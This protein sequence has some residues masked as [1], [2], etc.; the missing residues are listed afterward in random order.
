MNNAHLFIEAQDVFNR[1]ENVIAHFRAKGLTGSALQDIILFSYDLQSGS[2][3]KL[4]QENQKFQELAGSKGA[5]IAG[6]L[7]SLNIK[8]V[9]EAGTGEATTLRCV[10]ESCATDI[11]FSAFDISLSRLFY[12]QEF[13]K[14]LP[15]QP[16]FFSADF[17]NIPLPDNAVD[18]VLTVHAVE[19]NGGAEFDI[20]RE[21]WRVA[22][23]YLVLIEPDYERGSD[24]QKRRM[25]SHNYVRGIAGHLSK[26]P[27]NLVSYHPFPHNDNPLNAASVFVF[28]KPPVDAPVSAGYVSPISRSPLIQKDGF[29]YSKADGFLF[30]VVKN[31][32]CLQTR[33]GILASHY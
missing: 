28:E 12:A 32:P 31:I 23:R 15:R 18:A 29:L 13:V 30:P 33:M 10:M 25:E 8:T 4:V 16:D 22:R 2:Y 26:L 9:C 20:L 27:G 21:L 1:G 14:N 3:T 6:L 19:P 11:K 5:Y 24:D 17:I 7:D